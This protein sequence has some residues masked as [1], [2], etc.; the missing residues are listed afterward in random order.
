MQI[1]GAGNDIVFSMTYRLITGGA[2]ARV[3]MGI[4][5][6]FHL[7]FIRAGMGEFKSPNPLILLASPRGIEP[8]FSP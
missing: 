2:R 8:R 7:F 4:F 1:H 3:P 5:R 6:A